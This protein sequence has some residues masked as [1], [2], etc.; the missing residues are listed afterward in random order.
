MASKVPGVHLQGGG[1]SLNPATINS[2]P[3]IIRQ[4]AF[5][6][7]SRGLDWVFWW[8]IPASAL[9]FLLAL[10]VKEIP[11]RGR[12]DAPNKPATVT[13]EQL[14]AEAADLGAI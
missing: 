5:F 14:E 12:N 13:Q 1:G 3:P 10:W 9:V 8:T 6:A 7:I 4:A 2:L 11:L